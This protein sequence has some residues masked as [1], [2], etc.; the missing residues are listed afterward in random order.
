MTG[1]G[2]VDMGDLYHIRETIL[3]LWSKTRVDWGFASDRLA[4]AFR[5][6]KRLGARDRRAVSETLYGLIRQARRIDF[7]LEGAAPR[8]PTAGRP[9]E[10]A[11]LLA[12][13]VLTGERAPEAARAE[14]PEIDWSFVARVDERIARE[15][16]PVRRL[17]LSRSLPDWLARRLLEEYGEEADALAAALNDRA[18]LTIRANTLKTTREAL[19]A[20]LREEGIDSHPTRFSPVGLILDTRT[21]VYALGAF[22]EGL[23]EAMDEASQLVAELVAPPPR[24]LVVDACAGAGGKTL[25]I[26]AALESRGRIV[27]LDVSRRKL[28]ELRRRARRA[29]LSNVRAVPVEADFW[30][31]EIEALRGQADRVLVDVPCSGVGALRRNPEARWRLGEDDLA[32]LP[33]EQEAIAR[34]AMALV[35][36]GGRLVYATC[37]IFRAENQ[38]VVERLLRRDPAFELV[39]VAEIW[40]SERASRLC[41][42]TGTFLAT[43]PHRHDTDGFFA[44]VL[45]RKRV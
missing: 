33:R 20:R 10:R 16:D 36:P 23:L 21:N 35:A 44:A 38:D 1:V 5:R 42:A 39:R 7:A 24:G 11:Q 15:R 40:G 37:T 43:L 18:P 12:Y 30:P 9:R 2:F 8:L 19:A 6:E 32:R 34:R 13:E 26:G 4:D 14:M 28:E 17:G 22:R 31:D 25:A 3:D 27:A 41:D 45:R 29:G